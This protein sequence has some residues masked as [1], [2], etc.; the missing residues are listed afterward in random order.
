MQYECIMPCTCVTN[1]Q[2]FMQS[3]S[4][5]TRGTFEERA[6]WS[7]QLYDVDRDGFINEAVHM[8][9]AHRIS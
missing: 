7:F 5:S 1:L 9:C 8:L 3:L 6:E 2:D 4:V